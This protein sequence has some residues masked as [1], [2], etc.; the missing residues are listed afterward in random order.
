MGLSGT[1]LSQPGQLLADKL[2]K[3][4]AH[5]ERLPELTRQTSSHMWGTVY[6]DTDTWTECENA[7][8]IPVP[9]PLERIGW[10]GKTGYLGM[11]STNPQM[12]ATH[13][14]A[15]AYATAQSDRRLDRI[16][17][18][19]GYYSGNTRVTLSATVCTRDTLTTGMFSRGYATYETADTV[20]GSGSPVLLVTPDR[21]NN[22]GYY[23]DGWCD[24]VAYWVDGNV[25]YTLRVLGDEADPAAVYKTMQDLLKEI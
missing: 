2:L 15:T 5:Y 1:D 11:Q 22:T 17:I 6:V 13:V 24:Q 19:S 10:L 3:E 23:E 21:Q 12:Y 18:Q 25:F 8:G 9:N 16:D 7:L 20:T 4:W 14:K